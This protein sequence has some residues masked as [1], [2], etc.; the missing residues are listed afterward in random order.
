MNDTDESKR[1]P[2]GGLDT[3]RYGVIAG[4]IGSLVV[5]VL[6]GGADLV[7]GRPLFHTPGVLGLGMV[8]FPGE[9]AARSDILRFTAVHLLTFVA[10]G[11]G[12]AAA[13]TSVVCQWDWSRQRPVGMPPVGLRLSQESQSCQLY[14]E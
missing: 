1:P 2:H 11:I 3:L 12:L 4:L 8:G 10:I 13:A 14:C 6:Q 7:L 9:I 5:A